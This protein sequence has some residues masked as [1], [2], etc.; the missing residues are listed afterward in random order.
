MEFPFYLNY[1][2]FVTHYYDNL[3]KWFEEYHNTSETDFLKNVADIYRPYL[4]YNF[5][6]DRIQADASIR[7]KNCFFPYYEK[8]GLSFC[9]SCDNGKRQKDNKSSMN[10]VFEWKS[11]TMMEYAQHVLDKINRH[12]IKNEMS[13]KSENILDYINNYEIITSKEGA[14]Y[15]VNYNL[16][17]RT[18]SFLKAYL[19]CYGQTVDIAVYR[20]FIF[21]VAQIADFIDQKLRSVH[22]IENTIYSKLKSDAR[23]KVQMSHQFLTMCN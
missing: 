21:S 10:H 18:I 9:T 19:P 22:S 13:P 11:I 4:Y 14:G 6:N 20:D 23:F 2:D 7:I 5:A 8:I 16:H 15:C 1:K 12:F 3:E 17:Q